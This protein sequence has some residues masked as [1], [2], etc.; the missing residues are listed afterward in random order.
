VKTKIILGLII[1]IALGL[2]LSY[3]KSITFFYDQSR[4]AIA[5]MEIFHGDP[6][7]ITGPTTDIA[8]LNHGPLW[9]YLISPIYSLSGGNVYLV[10]IF[11]IL[12]NL[13]GIY[14][15]YDLTFDL[16]KNKSISLLSS[17]F[18]AVSFEA[19]AYGRWL[20]NPGPALLTTTISFWSLYKLLQGKKWAFIILLVSWGLTIQ[21]ELFTLYQ[22]LIFAAVWIASAGPVLPKVPKKTF[23]I[24][25]SGLFLTIS[26]YIIS[27][28]KFGFQG[29]KGFIEFFKT[30]SHFGSSFTSMLTDYL[31]RLT[32]VFFHNVWGINLF[33]AGIMTI[34]TLI[35]CYNNIR[36]GRIKKQII[37]LT[38]W[39]VSPI[40]VSF[41]SGPNATFTSLGAL[42]P[43]VILSAL[44]IYTL[45][46]K[47]KVFAVLAVIL[48]TAG[49]LGLVIAKNGEGDVLFTVQKQMILRD[50]VKVIDWIYGEASGAPFKLN[51]ITQPLFI[52]S[53]WA[54]LFNWYGQS[55]YGYMP[56]WWGENQIN[57][58]GSKIKFTQD[59]PAAY[60]FL[61]IEP[62]A[63]GD[64]FFVK[65]VKVLENGRSQFV[66]SERIGYF[67]VE[68]RKITKESETFTS[69]DVFRVIKGTD[70]E[71]LRK[72]Q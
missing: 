64:D 53:T 70:R 66:K 31:D 36:A 54:F 26:T 25:I 7:K 69:G 34:V 37:F 41:F 55:K 14:F 48:I 30:Q 3:F 47:T 68:K 20:S 60:E 19:I 61:I 28:V 9:W 44:L 50:E 42:I 10:K 38:I 24:G 33:L 49:N 22:I 65:A 52:N 71:E 35:F 45:S 67:T 62:G 43:V 56:I 5:S 2:R 29:T 57:V 8:G 1:V 6:I 40:V 16:F 58:P 13:A 17:F 27:E 18:Y 12:I 32:N 59:S 72:V 51:T 39:L 63:T 21:L 4:D 23:L 46:K 15:I 11:V